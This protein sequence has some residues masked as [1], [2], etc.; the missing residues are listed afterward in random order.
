M[1]AINYLHQFQNLLF[2]RFP[3]APYLLM[4]IGLLIS[5]S[6]GL[7]FAL[8]LR[9]R[10]QYWERNLSPQTLPRWGRL[11]LSLPFLGTAVGVCIALA[12][13]LEILGLSTLVAYLLSLLLTLGLGLIVWSQIGKTLGKRALRFYLAESHN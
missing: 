12:A 2:F 13:S 3:Q 8:S 11:Q 1:E 7:S 10:V 9:Q 5:L 6:C 4:A